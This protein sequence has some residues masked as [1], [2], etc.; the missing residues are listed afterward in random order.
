MKICSKNVNFWLQ[1]WKIL[2]KVPL[3]EILR[4]KTYQDG[5]DEENKILPKFQS[6]IICIC[7]G[8]YEDFFWFYSLLPTTN[9]L[10]N[11]EKKYATVKAPSVK[12]RLPKYTKTVLL[13]AISHFY[14]TM[15]SISSHKKVYSISSKVRA[16]LNNQKSGDAT[17]DLQK[18]FCFFMRIYSFFTL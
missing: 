3:N 4:F 12:K 1:T 8:T 14:K 13:S 16:A 9:F 7:H 17:L 10:L 15:H 18:T 5:L 11:I 6:L 2:A